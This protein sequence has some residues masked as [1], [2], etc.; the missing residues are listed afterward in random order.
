MRLKGLD[1]TYK[2]MTSK[3]QDFCD[4][5]IEKKCWTTTEHLFKSFNYLEKNLFRFH[6]M[7]HPSKSEFIFEMG[8]PEQWDG[9]RTFHLY[10][11]M[12]SNCFEEFGY[13]DED[14]IKMM[15]S[16]KLSFWYFHARKATI[17]LLNKDGESCLKP[18]DE[19]EMWRCMPVEMKKNYEYCEMINEGDDRA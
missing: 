12:D 6:L 5:C 4:H 14:I 13:D 7:L 9:T 17:Y 19:V 11:P 10:G 16:L 8:F 1:R 2:S 3:I 18:E 15:Y